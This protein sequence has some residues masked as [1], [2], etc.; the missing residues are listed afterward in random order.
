[1]RTQAERNLSRVRASLT[2]S[3]DHEAA[4][5][6]EIR[7]AI[8][9]LDDMRLPAYDREMRAAAILETAIGRTPRIPL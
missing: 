8:D 7:K 4:L 1:M 3:R 5:E 9:T 6:D 2:R